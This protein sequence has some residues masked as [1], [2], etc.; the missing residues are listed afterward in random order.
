MVCLL[1]FNF[2]VH[3]LKRV[4]FTEQR[5]WLSFC[6]IRNKYGAHSIQHTAHTNQFFFLFFF[7]LFR[8]YST[9]WGSF[10]IVHRRKEKK[11]GKCESKSKSKFMRCY[12]VFVNFIIAI[13]GHKLLNVD[14]MLNW[15]HK[16]RKKKKKTERL[17]TL[18]IGKKSNM[19]YSLH[20]VLN[21]LNVPKHLTT[22]SDTT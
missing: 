16:K 9:N 13:V 17:L 21:S 22:N 4:N 10:K 5:R 3:C 15:M 19:T 12:C 18:K 20:I 1:L 6:F 7:H 8:M 14:A 11:R 2:V